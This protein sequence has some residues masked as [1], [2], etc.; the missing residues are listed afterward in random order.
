MMMKIALKRTVYIVILVRKLELI[1]PFCLASNLHPFLHYIDSN[2]T[3][4]SRS[5][6]LSSRLQVELFLGTEQQ[7]ALQLRVFWA[8][9]GLHLTRFLWFD[10]LGYIRHNLKFRLNHNIFIDHGSISK[11]LTSATFYCKDREVMN[12]VQNRQLHQEPNPNLQPSASSRS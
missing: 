10:F 7:E 8:S 2:K 6:A 11:A 3:T 1:F 12:R 4:M 9:V 5:P